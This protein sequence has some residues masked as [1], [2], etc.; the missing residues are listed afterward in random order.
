MMDLYLWI[1]LAAVFKKMHTPL[2]LLYSYSWILCNSVHSRELGK[3]KTHM[4]THT[5]T[6]SQKKGGGH[7]MVPL[8]LTKAWTIKRQ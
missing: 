2:Y 5:K 6:Q 8:V 3:G 7:Q 4:C 1:Y